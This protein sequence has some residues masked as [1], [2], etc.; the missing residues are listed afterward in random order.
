MSGRASAWFALLRASLAPTVL[1]DLAAGVALASGAPGGLPQVARFAPISLLLFG[2]GMALNA[3][4]DRRHDALTRPERPLPSGR[5]SP[6]A[7]LVAALVGLAGAPLLAFVLA[8]AEAPERARDAALAALAVAGAI[9]LYH[10]PLK[11]HGVV[12][13]L[14]L[15]GVRAGDLLLGAVAVAG[16]APGVAAAWPFAALHGLYVVGASLVA[17][18]EDRAPRIGRARAGV[19]IALAAIGGAG[20]LALLDGPVAGAPQ[21]ALV[22]AL[23]QLF[24][25]RRALQLF[26]AGAPGDVPLSAYARLLLSRLPLIPAIACFAAGAGDLGLFSIGVYWCVFFLVRYVPPT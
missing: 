9:A 4:V 13:P 24:T 14:L 12:G 22:V 11:R 10:T 7:A 3:F 18:E 8:A 17:H 21:I 1:A 25:L 16:L 23:W 2:G 15:G 19:A 5:I 20:A 26:A 6:A